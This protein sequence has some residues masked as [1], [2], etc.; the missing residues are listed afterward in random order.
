MTT[1]VILAVLEVV[2]VACV[3]ALWSQ[4]ASVTRRLLWTPVVL[5]PVLGPLR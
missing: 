3:V 5:V 4:R 1:W 2:S